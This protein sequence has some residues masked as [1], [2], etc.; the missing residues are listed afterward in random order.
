M[1][2]FVI[3]FILI[4]LVG[5]RPLRYNENYIGQ[6]STTAI[7]GIFAII[8]LYN[9]SRQYLATSADWTASQYTN[10]Y[11]SIIDTF[12]Q[13]MVVMFLVYSG[14]GIMESY[15]RKKEN[16]IKGF[17]KKRILKT[18]VHFDMAVFAFLIL[19]LCLGSE[20]SINE[21]FLSFIGWASIG[22]SNWFVFDIVVLYILSYIGFLVIRR[23]NLNIKHF[24]WFITA[25]S[26]GF[27]I[28]M[29]KAKPGLTYWYDTIMAYPIG[30]LWSAYREKL[31]QILESQKSYVVAI[32]TIGILL[33]LTYNLGRT[34]KEVFLYLCSPIFAVFVI[35]ITMRLKIGNP[36]LHWLGVNAFAIYILQRIPMII[37]TEY[38]LHTTPV[39]FFSVI[40][41]ATL[42]IA[43]I[44]T[45][46]TKK[47]DRFAFS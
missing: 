22:N 45:Q 24:L 28:V 6:E 35:L 5:I 14:Y 43:Y 16:Y 42:L 30:M 12:G 7:K 25:L 33:V 44:F 15:K 17:F 3:I 8:I 36:V 29:Y 23:F 37:A 41:V 4:V 13:L 31:E 32:I 19:A 34:Y 26:C 40:L 27:L 39:F 38:G 10:L 46:T 47:I 2:L 1:D 18:L 11:N 20:Y 9:H 21:Y